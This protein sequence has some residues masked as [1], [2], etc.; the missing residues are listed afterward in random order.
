M[1]DLKPG[2]Y[3]EMWIP[4]SLCHDRFALTLDL[5]I[6][7]TD[8]PHLLIA[9]QLVADGLQWRVAYPGSYTSLS[10]MC[11]IAPADTLAVHRSAV[12]LAGRD[13]PLEV[14]TTGERAL[15]VDLAA[16][17]DD[18]C[19]WLAYLSTRYGPW[20]YG[21]R[22][23]AH[24]WA[25]GRGMEYDGATTAAVPALEHEVFHSWFGRGIKPA[26]A[27][28]GWIDEALT[29]W[30]TTT[31]RSDEGRFAEVALGLD[32]APVV[33]YPP[34]PWSRHTPAEAYTAGARLFAGMAE[35]LGGAERLRA[36][37]GA[38]Y[39]ANAGGFVTTAGLADHLSQRTG[40]DITPWWRRYV[41]GE[42]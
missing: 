15:G 17:A 39:R 4:A 42:A 5:T 12:A 23:T 3:L 16:C 24:V 33:L 25:P 35:L 40:V 31:R 10:P 41:H 7:G 9:N 13:R 28:D 30:A 19:G 8:R 18:I 6:T 22:Y 26:R 14:V 21:D 11:V 29:S 1:S 32:E 37:M 36:A 20:V 38:W 2:R 27:S 34:H